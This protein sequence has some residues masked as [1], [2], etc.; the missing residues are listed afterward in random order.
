LS[1]GEWRVRSFVYI[2]TMPADDELGAESVDRFSL[3]K[4][5]LRWTNDEKS[6]R[7]RADLVGFFRCGPVRK[8]PRELPGGAGPSSP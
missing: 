7:E 3:R 1:R 6:E 4:G 2:D 5:T 8:A